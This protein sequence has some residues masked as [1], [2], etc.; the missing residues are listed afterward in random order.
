MGSCI[1]YGMQ[2]MQSILGRSLYQGSAE[3]SA[4]KIYSLWSA[5]IILPYFKFMLNIAELCQAP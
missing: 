2:P 5:T 3:Q 4:W 1:V